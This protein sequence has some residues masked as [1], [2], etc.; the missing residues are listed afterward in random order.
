MDE[1]G[2]RDL[3]KF[4]FYR[5]RVGLY[6]LLK[7]LGIGKGDQ[8]ATQAY[9]CLAVPEGIIAS[10]AAPTYVDIDEYT[11]T[12]DPDDLAEKISPT[13]RAVIIQHTFGIPA[14]M[15]RIAEIAADKGISIIED[16]CHT[17]SS[18]YRGVPVGTFGVGAFCSYEWGKPLVV[19]IGG[20][21]LLNDKAVAGKMDELYRNFVY[22]PLVKVLKIQLQYHGFQLLY[23]PS[24]YWKIK[25]LFHALS[26]AGL[27]EGNYNP[28]DG[29]TAPDYSYRLAKSL[30]KR[31]SVKKKNT[32]K[33]V[34]RSRWVVEVFKS[35]I[36]N[37]GISHPVIPQEGEAVFVR[38][39][40]FTDKKVLL[41]E[42]AKLAG[43]E[44]ADW[45]N[46]PVH[47]LS[48]DSLALVKYAL[49][50]CPHAERA[51]TRVVSLPT[52]VK[53]SWRDVDKIVSFLNKVE[54]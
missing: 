44:M 26:S 6:A 28:I 4:T 54:L 33:H 18:T 29:A 53:T 31:L 15:D 8:V 36:K 34:E 38:Y 40:L 20:S 49:G 41:I 11:L 17:L 32:E 52:H 9:T 35:T 12:M 37:D 24:T 30:V 22:P 3:L 19:G 5:G 10:G 25:A 13:T 48:G 27:A 7:V 14:R 42:R 39:P 43:V 2:D 16:C 21:V 45:Y 50:S 47:P 46:S 51:C 23:R 1:S